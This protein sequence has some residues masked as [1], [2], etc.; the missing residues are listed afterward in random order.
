MSC[1]RALRD[2]GVTEIGIVAT[3]G[4]FTGDR[5]RALLAEGVQPIVDHRHRALTTPPRQA[6]VVPVAPLLAAVLE[7]R[8]D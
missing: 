5:W 8:H 4:L 1:C 6:R 7:G 2:A 3:H